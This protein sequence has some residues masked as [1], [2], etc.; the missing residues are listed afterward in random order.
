MSCN[1]ATF[2][3]IQSYL[4]SLD[5]PRSLAIWIMFRDNEHDQL[6]A[7][8]IDPNSY[9]DPYVFRLDYLATKFLSKADFLLTSVDKKAIALKSFLAAESSCKEV[10]RSLL[11]TSHLKN[12]RFDWLHNATSRKIE[13]ILRDFDGDEL[14]DCANWGPGV[15]LNRNIK[16][17]TSSTNKFRHEDGITRD[18]YDLVGHLHE[19]AYP[20]WKIEKFTFHAGNKIV[21]VPKNS[22]TDRTIA[23]EPGINLWFQKGI[24]TMIRRRLLR[25]GLDLNSQNRNQRMALQSS[26]S[27]RNATVDFSNASDSISLAAVEGLLPRRWFLLM[28]S[29]RS[30]F[31]SVDGSSFRY[32]KFS[33]MGNGFTFELETLIF[34]ALALSVC[35]Y[36]HASVSEVSV[37]GDDV[38]IPVEAFDLFRDIAKIYGFTVNESKSFRSGS[39]R[40]SCGSHYFAGINCKPYFLKKVV[41][42]E[43]DFYLA[44]N[45]IRRVARNSQMEFCDARFYQCWQFLVSSVAKPCKISEGYGDGGFIMN[46]DEAAPSRARHGIEGYHCR[47]LTSVPIRYYSDDQALLLARL[48]GRSV[49]MAFNNDTNLRNRVKYSRKRLFVRQWANLGPWF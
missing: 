32:E 18:A 25:Y 31:G 49:E 39:F 37:Y 43:L 29:F 34:Y 12:A 5:T 26:I 6:I 15:S 40:E 33:S 42:T 19:M 41:I 11:K 28:D 3:L 14:Y 10:N 17:D 13:K 44:A 20:T 30:H 2:R 48:K 38:I 45:S 24:G 27:G 46:F 36:L 7:L 35:E 1:K 8:D 23:I 21:T 16:F 9:L 4:E 47:A 22:K